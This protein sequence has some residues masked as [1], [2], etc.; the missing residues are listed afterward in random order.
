MATT[1]HPER[2]PAISEHWEWQLQGACR[3][4]DGELFFH[5]YGEREPSRSRRERDAQAVCARCP[6]LVRCRAYALAA[7]EP[8][9]VWGGLT[10]TDRQHIL[11]E[12]DASVVGA[13]RSADVA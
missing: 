8:Y 9:G 12:V 7:Q 13:S 10:E 4:A 3:Q 5:P 1:A 6:V 11:A 2:P